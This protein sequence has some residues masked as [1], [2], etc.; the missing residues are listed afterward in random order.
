MGGSEFGNSKNQWHLVDV[1]PNLIHKNIL[2]MFGVSDVRRSPFII[3]EYFEQVSLEIFARREGLQSQE[4]LMNLYQISLAL[5]WLNNRGIWFQ[6]LTCADVLIDVSNGLAKLDLLDIDSKGVLSEAPAVGSSVPCLRNIG[7]EVL[8]K[9]VSRSQDLSKSAALRR[10]RSL[11]ATVDW[12]EQIFAQPTIDEVV[13]AIYMDLLQPDRQILNSLKCAVD[14]HAW[15]LLEALVG[16]EKCATPCLHFFRPVLA[17]LYL[18]LADPKVRNLVVPLVENVMQFVNLYARSSLPVQLALTRHSIQV[19]TR[20]LEQ[21][22]DVDP[23][24]QLSWQRRLWE[25]PLK[26]WR[27]TFVIAWNA[28]ISDGMFEIVLSVAQTMISLK[29]WR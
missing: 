9:C 26:N 16:P 1:W 22:D 4:L 7:E 12:S 21:L 3:C 27:S 28:R 2:R 25:K 19:A 17:R 23:S 15:T 24:V 8:A 29:H 13:C 20:L 11:F 6:T 10:W 18:A 14:E 5:L